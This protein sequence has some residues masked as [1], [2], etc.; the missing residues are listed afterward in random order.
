VRNGVSA[1]DSFPGPHVAVT[2]HNGGSAAQ[3]QLVIYAVALRGGRVVGAGRA[4]VAS[5]G[6]DASSP[7]VIP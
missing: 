4:L 3:S 6:A 7:A 2:L 1:S 5:L